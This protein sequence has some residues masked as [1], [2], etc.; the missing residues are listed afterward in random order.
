MPMAVL[1]PCRLQL[2]IRRHLP[3]MAAFLFFSRIS[4]SGMLISPSVWGTKPR[5]YL[6]A[7]PQNVQGYLQDQLRVRS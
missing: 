2:L 3:T 7:G 4:T 5:S 6:V 1:V